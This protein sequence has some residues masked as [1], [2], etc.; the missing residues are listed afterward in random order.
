[1]CELAARVGAG[2]GCCGIE[3][4]AA[5]PDDCEAAAAA[6][7]ITGGAITAAASPAALG[8]G[9]G[10]AGG[11]EGTHCDGAGCACHGAGGGGMAIAGAAAGGSGVAGGASGWPESCAAFAGY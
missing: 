4:I 9:G 5:G 2:A 6:P 11:L 10:I 1:M 8:A 3:T 7:A